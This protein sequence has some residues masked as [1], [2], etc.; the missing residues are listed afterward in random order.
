MPDVHAKLSPSSS[1]RWLTCTKS[2]SL[3]SA[4]EDT[5]S[6]FAAEGTLAHSLGENMILFALDRITAKQYANRLKKIKNSQYYS[7][8]TLSKDE[9]TKK[10]RNK[11]SDFSINFEEE[12]AI[13]KKAAAYFA[14]NQK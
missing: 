13:L 10:M 8:V 3:E 11:Y 5:S 4:F 2:I 14:K 9:L 1:S 6:S 7:E 12:N